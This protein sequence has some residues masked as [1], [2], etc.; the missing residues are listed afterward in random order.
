VYVKGGG[1]CQGVVM[2]VV[3]VLKG[4]LGWGGWAGSTGVLRE[5]CGSRTCGKYVVALHM[6]Q[7]S[8]SPCPPPPSSSPHRPTNT[9]GT[10]L[11]GSH[12]QQTVTQPHWGSATHV[13][14]PRELH[15]SILL[16]KVVSMW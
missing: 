7:Y 9:I 13:C 2:V 16:A 8:A 1:G 11:C 3:V 12:T 6:H 15:D 14:P 5:G 4:G 10:E